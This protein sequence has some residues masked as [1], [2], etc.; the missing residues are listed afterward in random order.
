VRGSRWRGLA[1][2][3]APPLCTITAARLLTICQ[4]ALERADGGSADVD[5]LLASFLAAAHI[6][7]QSPG[8]EARVSIRLTDDVEL[9]LVTEFVRA[10]VA[11]ALT[12][13][14]QVQNA[15]E[16]DAWVEAE[17]T[18]GKLRPLADGEI[19]VSHPGTPDGRW[20][21]R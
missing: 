11:G 20:Q 2:P 19:V 13:V 15:A 21:T 18:W 14:T 3:G 16:I 1:P 5:A 7:T 10:M 9:A 17:I 6:G 4:R 12:S 8:I